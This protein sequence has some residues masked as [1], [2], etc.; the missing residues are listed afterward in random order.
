MKIYVTEIPTEAK[1]CLFSRKEFQAITTDMFTGQPTTVYAY[2][3]NINDKLCNVDCGG[4]CN[5]LIVFKPTQN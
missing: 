3:C 5:K 4:K 2:M 1:K